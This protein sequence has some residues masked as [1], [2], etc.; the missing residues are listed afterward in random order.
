MSNI[1]LRDSK[2]KAVR[3]YDLQ[4]V[5]CVCGKVF[6]ASTK[7]IE[8]GRGKYCSKKCMYENRPVPSGIIHHNWKGEDVGYSAI[9]SWVKRKLGKPSK[10]NECGFIS[11]NPNKIHW[12]NISHQYKRD[13]NDWIR[14]CAS[15]HKKYDLGVKKLCV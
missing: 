1:L 9:H 11:S 10:C 14:L 3:V 12:A 8:L 2:G 15:C 7:R 6:E 5:K 13:V 4:K